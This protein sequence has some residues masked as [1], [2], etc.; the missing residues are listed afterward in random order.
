MSGENNAKNASSWSSRSLASWRKHMFFYVILRYAGLTPARVLLF[1]VV[2]IYTLRPSVARRSLPY[3]QRRFGRASLF[4][5]WRQVW[6]LYWSFGNVL[7][8]R[9][10]TG[11]LGT[12]SIV[13]RGE[14]VARMQALMAEGKGLILL[15]AHVGLWQVAVSGFPPDVIV[16]IAMFRDAGDVDRHFFEHGSRG[17]SGGDWADIR[18]IDMKGPF[19]GFFEM[20]EA[21]KRGEVLCIMGD[22][23]DPAD[24]LKVTVN[25]LGG[26][27][28]LPAYPYLL[29]SRLGAPILLTLVWRTGPMAGE[30]LSEVIIRVPPGLG[31]SRLGSD[32]EAIRPYAQAYASAIEDFVQKHPEQFFNFYDMWIH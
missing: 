18:Q 7:L 15:S 32:E 9:A 8:E 20:G 3:L 5:R 17:D 1:F 19:G 26:Q 28:L 27:V 6:R 2:L 25:F 4:G 12:R 11:I 21:L 23:L 29:A 31:R 24:K 14:D 30:T 16:N 10:A 22:R 13:S